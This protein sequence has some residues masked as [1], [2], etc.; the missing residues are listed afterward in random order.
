MNILKRISTYLKNRDTIKYRLYKFLQKHS[1]VTAD[2]PVVIIWEFGGYGDILKKNAI[3]SA[4]L[5]LRG[6]KTH[7]IICDGTPEACIQRGA[8]KNEKVE[9]WKES[10]PKCIFRMRYNASQ[11]SADYSF[12]KDYVNDKEIDELKSISDKIDISDIYNYKYKGVDAG[13]LAWSSLV[14]YMKGYVI[15]KKD[16]KPEDEII[17]RKYFFAGLVNTLIAEKVIDKYRPVSVFCSHGVYVDYS[18]PI[19]LAYLKK[20]S[21]VSWSSGYKIL[22]H[23]FTIPKK[24]NRLEFRGMKD[25]EWKKRSETPLTEAENKFLDKYIYERFNKGNK[26]DF[27]NISLPESKAVLKEKLGIGNDNKTVCMFCHV[28]WDLSFDLST[29]IFENA[30]DWFDE[31]FRIMSEVKDINWIIRVHPG[32]KGSG[33]LYTVDDYIREKYPVIPEHIKILWS[34]SEINSYGL[35]QLID[36]GITLFG[37]TGAELPLLGKN[38][39]SGGEAYFSNKGFSLDAKSKEEYRELL[40]N[41]NNIK[42]LSSEQIETARRYAYSYFIQRQIPINVINKKEGHFGNLN[43]DKIS[44]LLPGK[45]LILDSI[46][47]SIIEGKDVILNEEMINIVDTELDD[48]FLP[49]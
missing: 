35:Y 43:P 10:C 30:N 23:Y 42:P 33:S 29:M 31:T 46:C 27:L 44:S 40:R 34:D 20:I 45:D 12:A 15:E 6:Y 7:F 8:E 28:A 19:L 17:Y 16:L 22:L 5:N 21:A 1:K 37:T 36:A 48:R 41:I 47:E 25:E 3:I 32:E 24:P 38:V 9:N 2:S 13:I 4:A 39:I 11:Y 26:A 49:L 14:R 18:P